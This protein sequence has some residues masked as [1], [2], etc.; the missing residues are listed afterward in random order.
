MGDI[1]EQFA[2]RALLGCADL[3]I[4]D[5]ESMAAFAEEV[6]HAF[7]QANLRC[8]IPPT[9][10]RPREPVECTK[11]LYSVVLRKPMIRFV[12]YDG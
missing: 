4:R 10:D 2:V 5:G 3:I 1:D 8:H 11:L 6:D 12:R 9:A 7:T